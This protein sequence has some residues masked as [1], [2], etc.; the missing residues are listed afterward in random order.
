MKI[1]ESKSIKNLIRFDFYYSYI[2]YISPL[3]KSKKMTLNDSN[4]LITFEGS[5]WIDLRI[6]TKWAKQIKLYCENEI[7]A[8]LCEPG[9]VIHHYNLNIL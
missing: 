8:M 1:G 4:R 6:I 3:T 5:S 9:Q 2:C 7:C